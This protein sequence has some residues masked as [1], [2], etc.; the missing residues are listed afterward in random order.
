MVGVYVGGGG[1]GQFSCESLG[2]AWPAN[3]SGDGM[4]RDPDYTT[5]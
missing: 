1:G 4:S 3:S 5:P 2:M